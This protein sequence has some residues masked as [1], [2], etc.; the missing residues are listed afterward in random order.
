MAVRGGKERNQTVTPGRAQAE[1]HCILGDISC[2]TPITPVSLT[3]GEDTLTKTMMGANEVLASCAGWLMVSA[4]NT[5]SCR[6]LASSNMRS[7]SLCTSAKEGEQL[8]RGS[9]HCLIQGFE[10]CCVVSR[11]DL[12]DSLGRQWTGQ[13]RADLG[14]GVGH[15]PKQKKSS[16]EH[17]IGREAEQRSAHQ[18]WI[19]PRSA[20]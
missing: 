19:G 10:G 12:T 15:G 3:F 5:T 9:A 20:Q 2:G 14:Q 1:V 18:C 17:Q 11:K 7:I 16:D 4:S 13:M 8:T 6:D